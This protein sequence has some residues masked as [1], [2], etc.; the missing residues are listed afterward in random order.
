MAHGP[1]LLV[2]RAVLS[3]VGLAK[4]REP[5][6]GGT[7][8]HTTTRNLAFSMGFVDPTLTNSNQHSEK[9]DAF[10]IGIC[11]LMSLVGV[12]AAGLLKDHEEDAIE[13]FE[14]GTGPLFGAAHVAAGWPSEATR[15][16]AAT[17]YGLSVARHRKRQPLAEALAQME[18]L[19]GSAT[20]GDT[21][22]PAPGPQARA[23]GYRTKEGPFSLPRPSRLRGGPMPTMAEGGSPAP[24]SQPAVMAAA[25]MVKSKKTSKGAAAA[26][27]A[28]GA[29]ADTAAAAWGATPRAAAGVGTGPAG[30]AS[31]EAAAV[32]TPS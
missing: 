8:T 2:H 25:A 13:A 23:P 11:A 4:V 10:G 31:L 19:L 9:T 15:A 3:D 6:F 28:V 24:I 18:A 21:A 20:T 1:P 5:T 30:V 22:A 14:D 17:V 27:A 12:P 29:G 26:K 32:S 7:T 16:L